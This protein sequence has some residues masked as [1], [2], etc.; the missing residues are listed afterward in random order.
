L[1]P[2]DHDHDD[3]IGHDHSGHDHSG[4]D[5][6][7][8][9]HIGHDHSHANTPARRLAIAL[10]ITAGFMFVEAAVGWLSGSLA[11][12][13]D[14]GHMLSDAAALV[15]ALFA[16]RIAS[17]PR[18]HAHTFGSRRAEVLAAF[19]NGVALAVTSL[20]IVHEAIGR[21]LTPVPIVGSWMLV[22]AIAGLG[23]NAVSALVLRSGSKHNLNTRAAYLHVLSDA[24]GSVGAIVAAVLVM[25]FQVRRADPIVSLFIAALILWGAWRLVRE[26]LT[27]LMEGTPAHIDIAAIEG[28]IRSVPGVC[29]VHDLH[30][31]TITEDF[32]V[33]TAHVVL[34][35]SRHGVEVVAE[36]ARAIQEKH[37]IEHVTLQPDAPLPGLVQI[38]IPARSKAPE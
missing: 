28:T 31:W 30:V 23:A 20:L 11:L 8:H 4:H 26:T 19:V 5:H 14:A 38:R 36:A 35:G 16:Q 32:P 3:H 10:V 24:L 22:T 29:E 34:N 25:V 13:A 9:D 18:S 27:V 37:G 33:L 1:S 12:M 17:R 15:L 2:H 21:L 6:S 7:G